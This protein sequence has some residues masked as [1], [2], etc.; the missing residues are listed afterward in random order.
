MNAYLFVDANTAEMLAVQP[1]CALGPK[2]VAIKGYEA[3]FVEQWVCAREVNCVVASYT[4]NSSDI[5]IA[6]TVFL[7]ANAD[8]FGAGSRQI[9]DSLSAMHLLPKKT[10]SGL[11]LVTNLSSLPSSWS[12]IPMPPQTQFAKAMKLFVVNENLRRLQ[13]MGRLAVA[14]EKPNT[15]AEAKFRSLFMVHLDVPIEF[16]VRELVTMLQLVLFYCDLLEGPYVDGLLCDITLTKIRDWWTK[17]GQRKFEAPLQSDPQ[18]F[19]ISAAAMVGWLTSM[20]SRLSALNYKPPKDP[21]DANLMTACIKQFQKTEKLPRSA[22]LDEKTTQKLYDLAAS[23]I[24]NPQSDFL[25]QSRPSVSG[26]S[27]T[28]SHLMTL[29]AKSAKGP[30][31]QYLW[32][33]R[34]QQYERVADSSAAEDIYCLATGLP[35]SSLRVDDK[36]SSQPKRSLVHRLRSKSRP[37]DRRPGELADPMIQ[38]GMSTHSLETSNTQNASTLGAS[39]MPSAP[40]LPFPQSLP[41]FSDI[42]VTSESDEHSDEVARRNSHRDSANEH[43]RLISEKLIGTRDDSAVCRTIPATRPQ[44][45]RA[46]SVSLVESVVSPT[47]KPVT[48]ARL[49]LLFR[50]ARELQEKVYERLHIDAKRCEELGHELE[51]RNSEVNVEFRQSENIKFQLHATNRKEY[52]VKVRMHELEA[53]MSKID[54]EYDIVGAKVREVEQAVADFG[55]KVEHL[56]KQFNEVRRTPMNWWR[57]LFGF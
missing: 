13:C 25:T 57:A 1:E 41:G 7:P 14:L 42:A 21:F 18:Y 27:S 30:R 29:V 22:R 23:R 43:W 9:F 6:N 8:D 37:A 10:E 34:G 17:F 36:V 47:K 49:Y 53:S 54:Y 44:R 2:Q 15:A 50:E 19:V 48:A 5:V 46:Q 51:R 45:P 24:R 20:R 32:Q 16:A 12:L 26:R 52:A 11:M 31:A 4:G 28:D 39:L 38:A 40:S 35:L 3:Y 33:G 55:A 56:E